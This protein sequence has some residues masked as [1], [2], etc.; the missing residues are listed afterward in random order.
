MNFAGVSSVSTHMCIQRT[1]AVEGVCISGD[2]PAIPTLFLRNGSEVDRATHRWT[3]P[4]GEGG[5]EEGEGEI[6]LAGY[7]A[8]SLP[9][10]CVGEMD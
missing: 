10:D 1:P 8:T 4:G 7:L 3:L 2:L 5:R 6:L 9:R